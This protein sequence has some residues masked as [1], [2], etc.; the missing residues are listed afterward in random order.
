[1][2]KDGP[3][4]IDL[5]VR[6][7]DAALA[8]VGPGLE[9][10]LAIQSRLRHCD[11]RT[12]TKFRRMFGGFYRVRRDA[13][14]QDAFYRLLERAKARQTT[15]GDVLSELH[16]ATGRWEASFVSKLLATVDPTQPVI[17][18]VVLRNVGLRLPAHG[19]PDRESRIVDLHGR[20]AAIFREFL[21]TEAGRCLV[22]RFRGR[23]PDADVTETKMLDL[24]L[25]QTRRKGRAG[26]Q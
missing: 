2:R 26:D 23:Y 12:D 6:D 19:A 7:I 20:L 15:F 4:K 16:S 25:W 1:M 21:S 9:K 24:V 22:S 17:D 8:N 18:S 11:I 13:C 5:T 10:Y 14:W 3:M